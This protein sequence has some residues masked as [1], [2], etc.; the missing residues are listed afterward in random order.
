MGT[1]ALVEWRCQT[2]G[3]GVDAAA[4]RAR[5]GT[6]GLCISEKGEVLESKGMKYEGSHPGYLIWVGS[7]DLL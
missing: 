6:L 3:S 4:S 1:D 5:Q 2:R 7:Y